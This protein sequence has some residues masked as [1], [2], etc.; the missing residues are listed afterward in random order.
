[1]NLKFDLQNYD[2]CLSCVLGLLFMCVYT[3]LC[4]CIIYVYELRP[5]SDLGP[6]RP[7]LVTHAQ[8][9]PCSPALGWGSRAS[10]CLRVA[11][12]TYGQHGHRPHLDIWFLVSHSDVTSSDFEC[13]CNIFL[14]FQCV[15]LDVTSFI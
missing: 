6:R 15:K 8:G 5:P 12:A 9:Q 13:F 2:S 10:H 1:V 4:I 3:N 14:M 7:H 11:A